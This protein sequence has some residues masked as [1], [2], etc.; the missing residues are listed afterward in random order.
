MSEKLFD[1]RCLITEH[2]NN[3]ANP[4]SDKL[5]M[6]TNKYQQYSQVDKA[7]SDRMEM[8][9]EECTVIV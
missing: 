4:S 7:A 8:Y 1:L 3:K 9:H 5:N 2:V 6:F